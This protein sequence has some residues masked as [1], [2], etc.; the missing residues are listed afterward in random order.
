MTFPYTAG[1]PNPPNN[2]SQDVPVMQTNANTINS[3]VQVDHTGFN[4]ANAG[5][6]KQVTFALNQAAPGFPNGCWTRHDLQK[7]W[8]PG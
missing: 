5:I 3:W 4:N 7:W 1:I 2:P 6:H 8:R